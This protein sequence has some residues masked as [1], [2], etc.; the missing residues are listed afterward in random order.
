MYFKSLAYLKFLLKS[1]N[2]HG[3]HSPFVF[4]YVTECLYVKPRLSKIKTQDILL[5][6]LTFFQSKEFLLFESNDLQKMI[7]STF[8]YKFTKHTP[9][10][11]AYYEHPD[12]S[13]VLYIIENDK[14]RN[15][16][17]VFLNAIHQNIEN[18]NIW[19]KLIALKKV[20]VSVDLFYCGVIF[21]RKEQQKEHFFIRP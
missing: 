14:I 15:N 2:E 21:I 1:T 11:F 5:R 3:L 4:K 12:Y 20:T 9:F 19:K 16:G 13:K 8:S 7:G 10:D 17:I 6:T 18:Q